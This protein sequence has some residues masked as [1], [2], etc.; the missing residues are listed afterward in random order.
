MRNYVLW[1]VLLS[2]AIAAPA[3]ADGMSYS[4]V[5]AAFVNTEIDNGSVD[6]DGDGFAIGGSFEINDAVFIIA[7][8]STQDFDFGIDLNQF[9]VGFGGRYP[10]NETVDVFGTLSYVDAE[11]DTNFGDADDNGYSIGAG[12]R[13][14]VGESVELQGG[15]TFLDLDDSGSDTA[16]AFGGRYYVTEQFAVGAG[17]EL[18]DDVTSWD[19][20]ARIEF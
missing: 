12:L 17:I 10:I 18:G 11:L 6:V 4:F 9:S 20:G 3:L 15:I 1:L 2:A 14:R 16:F 13:G 8:F 7:S 5:E 19:I